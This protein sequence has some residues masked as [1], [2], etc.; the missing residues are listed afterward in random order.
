M[1]SMNL[2][3]A[4]PPAAQLVSW[5]RTWMLAPSEGGL[6]LMD[7]FDLDAPGQVAFRF[8]TPSMPRVQS[9]GVAGGRQGCGWSLI[10][11]PPRWTG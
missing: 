6:R 5:Q 4:Y 9:G 8:I 10:A 2:A 1:L 7:V 11:W 3:C